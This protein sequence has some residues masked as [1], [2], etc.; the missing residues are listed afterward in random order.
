MAL[1]PP[2]AI[3]RPLSVI[4][5]ALY[6]VVRESPD[7]DHI[8]IDETARKD[9]AEQLR[10]QQ[11][12]NS[13]Q[14][15][16][17]VYRMH[18]ELREISRTLRPGEA[19]YHVVMREI[20][21]TFLPGPDARTPY[22]WIL[23]VSEDAPAMYDGRYTTT[24]RFYN[25]DLA[26]ALCD[27]KNKLPENFGVAHK[28]DGARPEDSQILLEA[29]CW[30][31]ECHDGRY[32]T[33]ARPVKDMGYTLRDAEAHRAGKA[34]RIEKREAEEKA[35]AAKAKREAE[36]AEW[37]RVHGPRLTGDQQQYIR[38]LGDRLEVLGGLELI[39]DLP[40]TTSE[41]YAL[42]KREASVLI[43]QL[44]P[45]IERLEIEQAKARFAVEETATTE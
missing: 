12:E 45:L 32:A 18:S 28:F 2:D 37:V 17:R 42:T 34:D 9:T 5:L 10:T 40:R 27:L 36:N 33:L 11:E 24:E 15:R 29:H 22:W 44:K 26:R 43:D 41:T 3:G 23:P 19:R 39:R 6:I 35:A 1:P 38:D 4:E 8:I 13:P 20:T 30:D 21:Q 25:E 7:G 16:Y 31:P 14:E